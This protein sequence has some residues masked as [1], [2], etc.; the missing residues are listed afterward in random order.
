[1]RTD[2]PAELDLLIAAGRLSLDPS[3][4][5][6]PI[7]TTAAT[8]AGSLRAAQRHG[9]TA[10]LAQ[11]LRHWPGVPDAVR[12]Q[13]ETTRRTQAALALKGIADV[14]AI[15]TRLRDAGVESVN[16][17]GPLYA[18][19]LYDDAGARRFADVDLV[20]TRDQRARAIDALGV[21]GYRFAGGFSEANARVVYAG[22]GSWPLTH[23]ARF[24]VDL[25]WM[26][27]APRFGS[28]FTGEELIG[29]SIETMAGGTAVRIP[30]PT[31]AAALMLVHAAK[32][33]WASLE[34]L[35]SIAHLMR[36]DDVDWARVRAMTTSGDGWTGAQAGLLLASDLFECDLPLALRGMPQS[37]DV[38]RLQSAARA[39]LSAPD[40]DDMPRGAEFRAHRAALD[41]R[42]SRLRY[43]AWRV[44]APTPLEA[45]WC[46][47]PGWLSPLYLVVRPVRLT[48]A[49]LRS[50]FGGI[51][52]FRAR[53]RPPIV[54]DGPL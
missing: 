51:P 9:M 36:R 54:R 43:T 48:V 49:G 25:H 11:A 53:R 8:W 40:V 44:L 35:L 12:A 15:V 5:T 18:R 7:T 31:H 20:I 21:D 2:L 3:R 50:V 27:Q 28:P 39:F 13:L 23:P 6:P 41:T 52:A 42:L 34:L 46:P 17:K 45:S 22:V 4:R 1:M 32:H 26:L 33:L 24:P 10:W 47:L 19:W 30:S 16:V 14:A 38:E 29:D 37:R